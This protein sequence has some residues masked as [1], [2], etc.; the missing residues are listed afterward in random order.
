MTNREQES[1]SEVGVVDLNPGYAVFQIAKAL[2][3]SEQHEDAETRERAKEKILKWMAVLNNMLDGSVAYGSRTPVKDTPEWATLEV[4]TGGFATG[5]LMAAGPLQEHE[6]ELL[7]SLGGVASGDE[8]RAINAQFLTDDG[9]A[10]LGD[11]LRTGRYEVNLPEEGALLVVAWLVENGYPEEARGLLEVIL[12]FMPKLRFYPVSLDAPRR[13]STRVHLEDVGG[14]IEKLQKIGPNSRIMAQKEAVEIWTPFHD[15]VVA[16]FLETRENDWPCQKYPDGWS[17][18]ALALVAEYKELRVNHQLCGKMDKP[19]GH[20]AQLRGL[21]DKCAKKPEK[22]SG[23][24]VGRIRHLVNCCVVKRGA[25]GSA[26]CDE[27]RQRQRAD[28][29]APPFHLISKVVIT[30]LGQ[31]PQKLGLDDVSHLNDEVSKEEA[32]D[33]GVA[34]GTGIPH[35]IQRK[36]ERCLNDTVEALIERG[37]ITSGDTLAI[38]LPQMTSRLRAA[39]ITDP[40]LRQLYAA[41]YRAFRRRRTLLLLNL[42]KQVQIEELPWIQAID[43]FREDNLSSRELA[44]QTLEEITAITL[45]SFPQAILPN[46]LLQELRA[47]VKGADLNIPL[48]DELAADIFMGQFSGKFI[49]SA[50]RAADLLDGSLYA[51]YYGINYGDIR[52]MPKE[53]EPAKRSWFRRPSNIRNNVFVELCASRAGVSIGGWDVVNNGMIIEQQQILTTQNLAALV[54]GIDLAHILRSHFSEM[55]KLCFRWVCRRQQVKADKFHARL[56][57]VKNTAY[58]WRQMVFYLSLMPVNEVADFMIWAGQYFDEQEERFRNRFMPALRGLSLAVEG[59]SPNNG[60]DARIFTGWSQKH[61][62]L[63]DVA[64]R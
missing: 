4:V 1:E 44:R 16:I 37:I 50:K 10:Q 53:G 22:L 28:V 14:T 2:T 5:G 54:G 13:H 32:K 3:T 43:R 11:W 33:S 31:H 12:P 26:T 35:T 17:D 9:L 64:K 47:L 52:N 21:L 49:E 23:K 61:W 7:D 15:R 38:V 46:K 59:R 34:Q 19:N 45:T 25:P 41:I 18:R 40:T 51:T 62:L 8:R 57:M 6:R 30:R 36:V 58:A 42:E 60:S 55:A 39:G 27:A 20:Y 48:V 63:D 29:S 24:E 56:I